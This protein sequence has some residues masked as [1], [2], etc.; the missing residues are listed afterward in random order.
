MATYGSETGVEAINAHLKGGYTTT[1][2]PTSA[3]IAGFLDD[4]YSAINS[5]LA[6]LGYAVPV[7]SGA[8]CYNAIVRLNNLFAAATAE[9]A[10]N[11]ST[12]EPEGETRSQR[13]WRRYESE[14]KALLAGDLTL[15]GLSKSSSAPARRRVRSVEMRRRDGYA[16]RFDSDNT[17]YAAASTD[18]I[19]L[20]EPWRLSSEYDST[21]DDAR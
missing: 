5:R 12:A 20:R 4:G 17:E 8:T 10:V 6:V 7:P 14:F 2:V 9:E 18:D 19:T 15:V 1:S 16:H 3:Q 13:L 21:V 11:I